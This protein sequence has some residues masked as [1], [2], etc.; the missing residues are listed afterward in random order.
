MGLDVVV[1]PATPSALAG[2]VVV[3]GASLVS[4]AG[5]EIELVD[6]DLESVL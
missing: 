3:E 5:V 6:D 1:V 4:V 2:A